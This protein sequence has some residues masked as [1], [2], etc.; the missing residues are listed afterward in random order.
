MK[1]RGS[2]TK[3]PKEKIIKAIKLYE[4][5]ELSWDEV[6]IK[7]Q[8]PKNVLQYHRRKER[9]TENGEST[10]CGAV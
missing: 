1:V 10:E 2:G 8:I 7:T 9:R 3:Y 6:S 5:S 4:T